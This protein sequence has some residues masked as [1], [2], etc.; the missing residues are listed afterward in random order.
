M[1][2]PDARRWMSVAMALEKRG[3]AVKAGRAYAAAVRVSPGDPETHV[4]LGRFCQRLR[5][6]SQA[7][8]HLRL[9]VSLGGRTS[10][11]P[12]FLGE[13][14]ESQGKIS[15][16]LK[17]FSAVSPAAR[18][19]SLEFK[20]G[21][22]R[23]LKGDHRAM[24]HHFRRFLA[25][26]KGR[27]EDPLQSFHA[28]MGLQEFGK[29]FAVLDGL[30]DGL[31]ATDR[32]RIHR[33]WPDHWLHPRTLRPGAKRFYRRQLGAL[34]RWSRAAPASV[35]PGFFKGCIHWRLYE[36]EAALKEMSCVEGLPEDRYGWL[37]YFPGLLRLT[38]RRHGEARLD[39]EAALRCSDGF[40]QARCHLAETLLC[41]G[42]R[43]AAFAEFDRAAVGDCR[44]EVW[45]WRGETLLWLGDHP[46]AAGWLDRAVGA[47]AWLGF[48]WRGAARMLAGD[49]EAASADLDRALLPGNLDAEA[50]VWR[51]E[52]KRRLRRYDEA[53]RDLDR[54]VALNE[55]NPWARV[56]RALTRMEM[57]EPRA[58]R[59]DFKRVPGRIV[60][61]ICAAAGCARPRTDAEIEAVLRRGLELA[62][63]VRRG[64]DYVQDLWMGRATP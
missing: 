5:L 36:F 12:R 53:L 29:A 50:S 55:S 14:F 26:D 39:F 17:S 8:A 64:E 51:G 6:P 4:A 10:S 63:G 35:W 42:D 34:R 22:L 3:L 30:S 33:P 62:G 31:R 7:E 54:A 20:M 56:N 57:G 40:W 59:A 46:R 60:E 48:G 49:Y 44:A 41:L 1:S 25:R 13:F 15:Q 21:W 24:R 38:L 16:A 45:A 58:M 52:L 47:G 18:E 37:R 2:S 19:P 43:P 27:G 32:E 11:A 28:W 61:R 23:G 9:A